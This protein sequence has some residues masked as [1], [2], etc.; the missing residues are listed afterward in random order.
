MSDGSTKK[1]KRNS[2]LSIGLVMAVGGFLATL[3]AYEPDYVA[4]MGK[5]SLLGPIA[6]VICVIGIVVLIYGIRNRN[7]DT[8]ERK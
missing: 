1:R 6:I 8:S 5:P 2:Y 4:L 3:R 7:L